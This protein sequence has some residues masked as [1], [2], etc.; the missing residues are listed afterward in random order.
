MNAIASFNEACA[1]LAAGLAIALPCPPD[2]RFM[3]GLILTLVVLGP[4]SV[5]LFVLWNRPITARRRDTRLTADR[6]T[7]L[8]ARMIEPRNP[9]TAAAGLAPK[10]LPVRLAGGFEPSPAN[11]PSRPVVNG[12]DEGPGCR[13]RYQGWRP[14]TRLAR[15]TCTTCGEESSS[16]HERHPPVQCRGISRS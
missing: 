16:L 6:I 9:H 1:G 13:W 4:L 10:R 7:R 11:M 8:R 14:G 12:L 5:A 15:W 3:G 2:P